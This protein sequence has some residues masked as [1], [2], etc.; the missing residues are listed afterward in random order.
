MKNRI[1][2]LLL[3]F[4]SL[5]V[6]IN[7]N[8][9]LAQTTIFSE[10]GGGAFPAGW[11]GVNNVTTNIIDK[12]SYYLVDAGNPSDVITTAS[13]DLS[14]MDRQNFHSILDH[15]VLVHTEVQ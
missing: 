10:A 4:V 9:F 15:M 6:Q 8:A 3:L 2:S 7:W 14:A 5:L 13:Y 11:S 1:F 12:G